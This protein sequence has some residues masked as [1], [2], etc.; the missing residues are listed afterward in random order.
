MKTRLQRWGNK[1]NIET[2]T[3][4]LR[5]F[6]NNGDRDLRLK[7]FRFMGMPPDFENVVLPNEKDTAESSQWLSVKTRAM[8]VDALMD[9]AQG[10]QTGTNFPYG[11]GP[12]TL[13]KKFKQV[14]SSAFSTTLSIMYPIIAEPDESYESVLK[15]V[16]YPMTHLWPKGVVQRY[17]HFHRVFRLHRQNLFSDYESNGGK[18]DKLHCPESSVTEDDE[19]DEDVEVNVSSQVDNVFDMTNE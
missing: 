7:F 15:E 3:Q 4:P 10:P 1:S 19:E 6:V 16:S 17:L 5:E 2:C 14:S 11:K 18:Y 13:K 12:A 9:Y 8:I